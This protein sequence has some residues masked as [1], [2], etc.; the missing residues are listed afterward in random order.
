MIGV[1][2][3]PPQRYLVV[4]APA[5]LAEHGTPQH[6]RELTRHACIGYRL[7]PPITIAGPLPARRVPC[8]R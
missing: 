8:W 1:P 2:L 4:A 5:Y 7:T 6:P 3:G